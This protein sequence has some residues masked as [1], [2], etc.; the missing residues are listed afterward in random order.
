M[1]SRQ[2]RTFELRATVALGFLRLFAAQKEALAKNQG[3]PV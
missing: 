1:L 3:R 2:F